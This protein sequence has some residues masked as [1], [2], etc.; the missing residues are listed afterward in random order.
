MKKAV[1]MFLAAAM[2][3]SLA[4]CGG[5][6]KG[7]GQQTAGP[8]TEA[9]Q[10]SGGADSGTEEKEPEAPAEG[11]G[12]SRLVYGVTSTMSGDMGFNQWSSL[13]GDKPV[14]FLA[15][16]M[17]PTCYDQDAQWLWDETIVASHDAVSNPDGTLTYTITLNGDHSEE[18]CRL[19][20]S[21]LFTGSCGGERLRHDRKRVCRA[22]GVQG[23]RK[24]GFC[25]DQPGG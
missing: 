13:G 25:G 15:E 17:A 3:C 24:P 21:V 5:G 8:A 22:A 14:I 23:R 2:V 18:L 9:A 7:G 12:E 10:P 11:S 19:S 20:A 4:A 1:S 6:D 16:A